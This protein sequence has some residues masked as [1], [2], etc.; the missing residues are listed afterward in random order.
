MYSIYPSISD[1]LSFIISYTDK[2][3]STSIR[4]RINCCEDIMNHVDCV[5]KHD[6]Y[7]QKIHSCSQNSAITFFVLKISMVHQEKIY[8]KCYC[9]GI[10]L[11]KEKYYIESSIVFYSISCYVHT[12]FYLAL[13]MCVFILNSFPCGYF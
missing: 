9:M 4:K 6:V 3:E 10:L 5:I 1:L 7:P 13:Y 12:Q 8:H 11:V 2:H